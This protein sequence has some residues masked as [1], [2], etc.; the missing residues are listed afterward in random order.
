MTLHIYLSARMDPREST[1]FSTYASIL[2]RLPK[3]QHGETVGKLTYWRGFDGDRVS[4]AAFSH[5]GSDAEVRK[6][7]RGIPMSH[8]LSDALGEA[9]L[10]CLDFA[11][12][13]RTKGANIYRFHD[14]SRSCSL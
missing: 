2:S 6:R 1:L 10:F 13:Q 5:D 3:P 8:I 7:Q 9:V 4:H 12:N 14:C 11:V